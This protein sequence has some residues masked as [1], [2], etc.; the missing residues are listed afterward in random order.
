MWNYF[1]IVVYWIKEIKFNLLVCLFLVKMWLSSNLIDKMWEKYW[2]GFVYCILEK[3]KIEG[4][5]GME[6]GRENEN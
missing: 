1:E 6:E 4:E 3:G 2:I 5:G